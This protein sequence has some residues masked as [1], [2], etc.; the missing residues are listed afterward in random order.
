MRRILLAGCL[1]AVALGL[2]EPGAAPADASGA[3][4]VEHG[5]TVPG[6]AR[7]TGRVVQYSQPVAGEVLRGFDAPAHAFAAGHRG[8][9][10]AAAPGQVIRAA[11]AGRV[12]HAGPVAGTTWVS[13]AHDDGVL[14][15]YGP[16][17][18][19]MVERGEQVG[20][21]QPIAVLAS[22]GYGNH[23]DDRLHWGARG[24]DARYLDPLEL[25]AGWPPLISLVGSGS[26]EGSDHQHRRPE[27]WA[28]GR[29]GG[30]VV[31]SSQEATGPV[32]P[33]APNPNHLVILGGLASSGDDPV[34]GATDLGHD[35]RSVTQFSYAGRSAASGQADD[36]WRD[37]LPY[38][39]ADTWY[40]PGPAAARLAEQLRAIAA[41]EPGR[42][43][44]LVGHSMG[45][46]IIMRYL[47]EHHDAYDP[48]L[49]PI[50]NVV[51]I[52]AP[53]RGADVA[54]AGTAITR[55]RS[56]Q[57]LAR[58]HPLVHHLPLEA[59]AVTDLAVGSEQVET[60]AAGWDEAVR[61]GAGGPL[62]MGTRVLTIGGANDP[63]VPLH[64]SRP[65]R[66]AGITA[67]DGT[68]ELEQRTTIE[69]RALP[70]S[71]G[72]VLDTDAV[73]EVAWRFLAGQEV[74]A[75]PGHLDALLGRGIGAFAR[76]LGRNLDDAYVPEVIREA[77]A[78]GGVALPIPA[79]P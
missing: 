52:A 73:R 21:G 39:A 4:P 11:A 26:W 12:E 61:S 5:L 15:S 66:V 58:R 71:H 22:G 60:L 41:R 9:D 1:A 2:V 20:R 75:S 68:A 6:S 37:Q 78:P 55:G 59:P 76:G 74:P 42:A 50:G 51:T 19:L 30:L 67:R 35:P 56:L 62:A 57:H 49:P 27:P 46:V 24:R 34:L 63:V 33:T 54:V 16:L 18:G 28:G 25:L 77:L 44:D 45:G 13:I 17:T 38:H 32:A 36:P 14:T 70:G 65:P 40:G 23:A 7:D 3:L 31:G 69:H 47:A 48:G 10:L 64:R 53:L 72:G 79:L 43:V 8:V 29:L